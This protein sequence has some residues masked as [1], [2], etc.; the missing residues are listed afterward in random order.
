MAL[1]A[2]L[3][4]ILSTIAKYRLQEFA[5][6]TPAGI[7]LTLI[8]LPFSIRWLIGSHHQATLEVRLRLALE[9]LGPIYI[10]L[11]QL[12]STRRDFLDPALADELANLQDNVPPFTTPHIHQILEQELGAEAVG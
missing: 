6:H 5:R 9:E 4:V 10:K 12:I 2:R 3:F 8:L 7:W 1:V 11:G